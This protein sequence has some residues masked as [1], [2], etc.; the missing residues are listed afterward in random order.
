VRC[1][2]EALS[3]SAHADYEQTSGFL[4]GLQPPHVVLVHG[5]RGEMMKLRAVSLEWW[6]MRR[7]DGWLLRLLDSRRMLAGAACG[8]SLR[9]ACASAVEGWESHAGMRKDV[10]HRAESRS[11]SR[12]QQ[13]G[14]VSAIH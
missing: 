9:R 13:L 12:R 11:E 14:T 3:F 1:K 5:E 4:D 7:S 2:V 10:Q 8:C 6:L